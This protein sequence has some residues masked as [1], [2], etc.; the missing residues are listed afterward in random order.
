MDY[1]KYIDD[2]KQI[3]G[4]L[5]VGIINLKA[6]DDITISKEN[7]IEFKKVLEDLCQILPEKVLDLEISSFR[8]KGAVH[9]II[10]F[11]EQEIL[12]VFIVLNNINLS[13]LKSKLDA[14][15]NDLL[16]YS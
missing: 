2:F 10:G 9:S 3:S 1:N 6:C 5:S 16:I 11:I 12:I 13:I 14:F 8:F 7:L 15:L 4:M